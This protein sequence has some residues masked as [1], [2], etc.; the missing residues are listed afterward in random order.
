[1]IVL[2]GMQ[3]CMYMYGELGQANLVQSPPGVQT[4]CHH[5]G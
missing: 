3:V 4:W 5:V 1:M 2:I